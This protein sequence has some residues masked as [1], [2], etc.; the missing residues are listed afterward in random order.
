MQQYKSSIFY[1]NLPFLFLLASRYIC[2]NL[3][4]SHYL[5]FH[6]TDI[7][8]PTPPS[9]PFLPTL[10]PPLARASRHHYCYLLPPLTPNTSGSVTTAASKQQ[11]LSHHRCHHQHRT[12]ASLS[13]R[14]DRH[15]KAL[16][17]PFLSCLWGTLM[18]GRGEGGGG[19]RILRRE[20]GSGGGREGHEGKE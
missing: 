16:T 17:L 6:L 2:I 9:S 18:C 13:H 15:K 1:L 4:V 19:G 3:S 8:L 11:R 10:P 7:S 12:H 5:P 14:R 20:I